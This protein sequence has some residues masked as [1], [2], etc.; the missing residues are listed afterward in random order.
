MLWC[1]PHRSSGRDETAT[2]H[3][4]EAF[5]LALTAA[6]MQRTGARVFAALLSSEAASL[7]AREV[8]ETVQ[9]SPAAVSGAVRYLENGGRTTRR[10]HPGRRVDD[11]ERRGDFWYAAAP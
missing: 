3:F 10:R 11:C 9:V 7:T 1:M 5:A 6:G 2:R 8:A 4:I